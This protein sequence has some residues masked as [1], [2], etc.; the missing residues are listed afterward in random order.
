MRELT[1]AGRLVRF[2]LRRDRWMLAWWTL[3]AVLLYWSQAISVDGLYPTQAEF[4]QAAA[5][6]ADN[7]AF[8][9]MAGPARALNT[10]G[11]QV[12]WQCAAFGA[13]LAGLMSMFVVGRHTRAEEESGRDEL[14][15]SAAIG[16]AAPLV[17]TAAVMALAN[18][19]LA[20][21]ISVSL[22]AYGLEVEGSLVLGVAAGLAGL[23]FG[24][25]TLVAA[26]LTSGVRATYAVTGAAIAAS[27]VIR[28]IGDAA[29]NGL[30]W[31][32]PIGWGQ[33]MQAFAG[34][35][36]WPALVSI[37]ASAV[38]AVAAARLFD[39]RDVGAG[40]WPPRPGPAR[41]AAGLTTPLG[42]EWRLQR[43]AVIG[44]SLGLLLGGYAYGTIGDDVGEIVGDSGLADDL[45]GLDRAHLVDSFY[46]TSAAM[47]ALVACGFA[48]SSIGRMRSEE[49]AGRAEVV[50]ATAVPRSR[51]AAA[52]LLVTLAGS[53]VAVLLAGV[54]MGLGYLTVTG[55][56]G[57]IWRLAAAT[58]P[59][60]LPVLVVAAVAWLGSALRR[61]LSALGWLL[62]VW[63]AVVLLFG[64]TLRMPGWLLRTSPFEWL[65][66]MPLEG[67]EVLPALGLVAVIAV[68]TTAGFVAFGRR[69]LTTA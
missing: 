47:L 54:G 62:V 21:A 50:L 31:L 14:I 39:R 1:G 48:V 5:R 8:I 30:S 19:L 36:W 67:F 17:A 16:R 35:R 10:V 26:Q 55:D 61:G 42:L 38:L 60:C 40:I 69:D 20:V 28:A 64:A 33:S 68:L 7:T 9:A 57:A 53:V 2:F 27:Y 29:G 65:P 66:R 41:A 25:I 46:A 56:A 12:A 58:V 15:R 52:H 32:S 37:A 24:S 3:G 23:V 34:E 44:W 18:V 22:I 13:I 4:D 59:Q 43:W 63:A 11:G 45:F 6:M 51:W 49:S